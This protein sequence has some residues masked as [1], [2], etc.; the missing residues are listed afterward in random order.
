M[1]RK[2]PSAR[3][4]AV[5]TPA[6]LPAIVRD[7][8]MLPANPEVIANGMLG[9]VQELVGMAAH[10]SADVARSQVTPAKLMQFTASV[11]ANA[12]LLAHMGMGLQAEAKRQQDCRAQERLTD[13]IASKSGE[14]LKLLR[15][16]LS[17]FGS[18]WAFH[19]YNDETGVMSR[20]PMGK[21]IA[22]LLQ[23]GDVV[24]VNAGS[25]AVEEANG[26]S[27]TFRPGETLSEAERQ[28]R[29]TEARLKAA[30]GVL[31]PVLPRSEES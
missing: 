4:L 13:L 30:G 14:A 12:M 19:R 21:L 25:G 20:V 26:I 2:K 8:E 1:K 23:Q 11:N 27:E 6:P 7:E 10:M 28:K 15:I 16:C 29:T 31:M 9:R 24:P 3:A 5:A 22:D 18:D 17:S